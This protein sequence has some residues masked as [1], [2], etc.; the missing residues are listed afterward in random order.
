[1]L[2]GAQRRAQSGIEP[3]VPSP[4]QPWD[5]RRISH[6]LRR[7]TFFPS[8][9]EL[10]SHEGKTP[11][12]LVELLL[13]PVSDPPAPGS[14]VNEIFDRPTTQEERTQYE[15]RNKSLMDVLRFWWADLMVQSGMNV[16]EK[17]ILFWHGHITAEGKEIHIPQYIYQ[18]NMLFRQFATGSFRDLMKEVNHDPAMLRYLN[19]DINIGTNPNENYG[20][21]LMELFTMGEGHYT[22]Q[23]IKEAA[24]C[25]TG[26]RLDEFV[27]YD[28]TFNPLFHD[29]NNKT[30]MGRTILGR[31]SLDG[32]F[33]GDEVVDI[34]FE[35]PAV[36]K[37]ICRKLYLAF[38]YNNPQAVDGVVVDA[39]AQ[40]FRDNDYQI[41]PVLATLLKSAHFF[42]DVN[43]GAMI[44]SPSVFELGMARQF[45]TNPGSSRLVSDM[46]TLEQHL[47]D[48]PNVA[49]W[50]GYRTWIS[51]TTYPYRKSF[52]GRFITGQI[53]G[54][55]SQTPID[56]IAWGKSFD[57]Y[58]DANKLIDNILLLLLPQKV[59]DTRRDSYLKTMLN[60]APVYE[61]NI[62]SPNADTNLRNLLLRIVE[63]P[64][65]QLH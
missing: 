45:A 14:W 56:V 16:H 29:A 38:V 61:W 26:W 33:E 44:K 11:D 65:F 51:T 59:S 52:A 9:S 30:F 12:E 19:G 48:P 31:S 25:L 60:N 43:I 35:D 37:F 55:T 7:A 23:D 64:D 17:M 41:K 34:I 1:M 4:Q 63:A 18:Q 62:N 15:S 42:D 53:P 32:R 22:E 3:Y 2:Y 36:A 10:K 21:E 58:A 5:L 8:W 47:L 27:T 39:L 13:A 24:R 54:G 28:S 40:V 20:R 49:G 57:D 6:L 50:E 46:K